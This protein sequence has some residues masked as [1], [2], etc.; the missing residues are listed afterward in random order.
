VPFTLRRSTPR[1][2]ICVLSH[3]ALDLSKRALLSGKVLWRTAVGTFI[4]CSPG[5]GVKTSHV[6]DQSAA[7][8]RLAGGWQS[9]CRSRVYSKWTA[10]GWNGNLDMAGTGLLGIAKPGVGMNNRRFKSTGDKG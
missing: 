7:D 6:D 8:R 5:A 10:G 3:R 2:A 4:F 1:P 9:C